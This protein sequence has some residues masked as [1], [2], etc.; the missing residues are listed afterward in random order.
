MKEDKYRQC[1]F[2]K[3]EHRT[4]AYIP[5]WAAKRGNQVQ[6]LTLDGEFWTVTEVGEEVD[7]EFVKENERN[8]KEFQGSLNGGGID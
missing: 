7:A 3:G 2:T 6:L 5:S 1:R 4:M 8:Y